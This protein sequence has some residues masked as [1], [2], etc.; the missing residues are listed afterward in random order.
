MTKPPIGHT[1][2]LVIES[3]KPVMPVTRG[4]PAGTPLL[5]WKEKA[6]PKPFL[7]LEVQINRLENNKNLTI[8][9]HD[10]AKWMLRQIGNLGL[11]GGYKTPFKN[12]TTKKYKDGTNF[13]DIVIAFRYLL[14]DEDFK[15]FKWVFPA[16]WSIIL[17]PQGQCP[18]LIYIDIWDSRIIGKRYPV[19][20]N[21]HRL[22]TKLRRF[23]LSMFETL[24][25][26]NKRYS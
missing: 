17:K 16:S 1:L 13:E 7:S 5:F 8:S 21:N 14:P 22:R 23:F 25:F 12:P 9:D 10:Y 15:K 11:I 3:Q 4:V 24:I 26:P 18:R 2:C 20:E 6:I 19:T